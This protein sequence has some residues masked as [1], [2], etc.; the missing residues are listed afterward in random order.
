MKKITCMI[1]TALLTSVSCLAAFAGTW[2]QNSAGWWWDNG[3][4]TWPA[5]QWAW[6]DGNLD[7]T[8]ECYYFDQ[9]G[10]CLRNTITPDGYQVNE[11]GAWTVNGIVQTQYVGAQEPEHQD[12]PAG[13]QASSG[14]SQGYSLI[15]Y[16]NIST[17]EGGQDFGYLNL[18]ADGTGALQIG[19]DSPRYTLSWSSNG[20][21]LHLSYGFDDHIAYYYYGELG[22]IRLP[23][24]DCV[25]Y[26]QAV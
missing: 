20:D 17:G 4:G 8:A 1:I 16:D 9:N 6:C 13:V 24:G 22:Q 26:F 25:F 18:E 15:G 10:Y 2:Q 23:L 21:E 19:Y 12:I 3:N 11:N 14:L 7:G 5:G